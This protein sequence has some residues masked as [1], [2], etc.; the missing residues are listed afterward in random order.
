MPTGSS[1]RPLPKPF[2]RALELAERGRETTRP[3]PLV[4]A[5]VVRDGEVVGEGWHERAGGPHA[6]VV[7]LEAAGERAR[8]A[9]LYVTLEPCAHHGRT[10]PCVDAILAAGIARVV[11]GAAD[12]NPETDGQGFAGLEAGGVDVEVAEEELAVRA[13]RQNEAWRTWISEGRPF[14]TYKAAVTL[15]GR[16]TVPG[17]RWIT[18]EESR[19]RVHELRAASDAVGV[20]MGTVRAD[21]PRLDARGVAVE[22][23]PRRLAFGGGPLPEGSEL[24][25]VSGPLGDELQRL[26]GEGVQSLLLEGG[27]TLATALLRAGLVDRLLLFVAPLVAGSGPRWVGELGEPLLVTGLQA[28]RIGKDVLLSGYFHEP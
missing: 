10:P 3:N 23:Q 1:S 12:P 16:V 7:A 27:P 4:G 22:C 25:L 8:G 5:V 19:R 2:E 18:G 14:V 15:D 20:G 6:E 9:V 28:E 13:R 17:E 11:V 21:A 24:E 26:G